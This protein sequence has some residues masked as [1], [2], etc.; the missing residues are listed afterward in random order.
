VAAVDWDSRHAS[1]S[2]ALP[3]PVFRYIVKA[4]HGWLP[5]QTHHHKI[6]PR[7]TEACLL[8]GQRDTQEHIFQCPN[9]ATWRAL[10]LKTTE[11]T[12]QHLTTPASM[13]RSLLHCL[14]RW[15]RDVPYTTG[16]QEQG[17][18]VPGWERAMYGYLPVQWATAQ[19]HNTSCTP[20]DRG[21][22]W[23]RTMI[24]HFTNTAWI[25]RCNL[26][27]TDDPDTPSASRQAWQA[28]IRGL[29]DDRHQ[30]LVYDRKLFELDLESFFRRASERRLHS[31]YATAIQF[32]KESILRAHTQNQM[33]VRSLHHYF[34]P[35]SSQACY[36]P[37][38]R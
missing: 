14:D 34:Q 16:S 5:T 10:F 32:Y 9:M 6:D 13:T 37:A 2:A 17:D 30:L 1:L 28:K 3:G 22:R 25:D 38:D 33:G 29:C 20:D 8:C 18:A 36:L 19:P 35:Q 11:D 23:T 7:V 12:L 27:H 24:N 15:L 4:S 31:W 26:I 21:N